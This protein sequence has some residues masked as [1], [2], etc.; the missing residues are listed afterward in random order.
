MIAPAHYAAGVPLT[1]PPEL[2]ETLGA[3]PSARVAWGELP[4]DV[5]SGLISYVKDGW[6]R[7]TRRRRAAVIADQCACGSDAA[8]AWVFSMR[9]AVQLSRAYDLPGN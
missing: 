2:E 8:L 4:I 1:L 9:R 5:Q 7:R 3:A 6:L